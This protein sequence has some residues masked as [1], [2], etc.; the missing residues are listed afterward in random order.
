M[1]NLFY[2]WHRSIG[3]LAVLFVLMLVITGIMLNHT[4]ELS[5]DAIYIENDFILGWY[6]ISPEQKPSG[7]KIDNVWVTQLDKH[8]YFN[9]REI[10]DQAGQLHGA[11][12]HNGHIVVAVD[13]RLILLTNR[14]EIIEQLTGTE[15]VPAGMEAIGISRDGYLIIHAAHG[16][17][18]VDLDE[19]GWEENEYVEI[20]WAEIGT[21]PP[22][23]Y[24]KIIRHYRGSGLPLERIIL[25]LHSGRI[26]GDWGIYLIDTAAILLMLLAISGVWMWLLAHD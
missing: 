7:Y 17:Y 24:S 9:Q 13:N 10:D 25:D 6:D 14:G 26:L 12:K 23:L 20:A 3:I 18:R 1:R 5:L 11:V 21:I 8:I 4:E 19:L 16:N 2:R 15:G 22:E